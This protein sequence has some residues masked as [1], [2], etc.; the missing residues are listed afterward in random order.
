M[1]SLD[2]TLFLQFG[3][4]IILLVI[5]HFLLYRPLLRIME[6]RRQATEGGHERARELE[7]EIQS[8]IKAYRDKLHEAKTRASEERAAMRTAAAEEERRILA[9][10][11]QKSSAQIQ[12]VRD[13]VAKQAEE[14]RKGLRSE[15]QDLARQVAS[16]VL[17]R[18]L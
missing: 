9:E 11:Q 12:S 8:R 16:K 1:I 17:G 6:E 3:N 4:F 10:A 7:D 2:W 13:Q 15:A 5:L 14:A 18:S